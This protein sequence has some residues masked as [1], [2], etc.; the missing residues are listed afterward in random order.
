MDDF[1][2]KIVLLEYV[3]SLR[4]R[5]F[6]HLETLDTSHC[7]DSSWL[8]SFPVG[9]HKIKRV[10]YGCLSG[11]GSRHHPYSSLIDPARLGK[12]ISVGYVP[13]GAV[14]DGDRGDPL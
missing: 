12:D 13:R 1:V 5:S 3:P 9:F 7:T 6:Q 2:D 4:A 14:T 11:Y 8:A 10:S